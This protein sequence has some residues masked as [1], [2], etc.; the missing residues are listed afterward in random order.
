MAVA[1]KG[2]D[3]NGK[4]KEKSLEYALPQNGQSDRGSRF[5]ALLL[6]DD[7]GNNQTEGGESSIAILN[8][9]MPI[10]TDPHVLNGSKKSNVRKTSL[11]S[12]LADK[13]LPRA[14]N[15]FFFKKRCYQKSPKHSYLNRNDTIQ[16]HAKS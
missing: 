10:P 15:N 16:T 2:R 6:D 12:K 14:Q 1:R 13:Q 4:R 3:Q 7:G 11:D 5:G 9:R 8:N